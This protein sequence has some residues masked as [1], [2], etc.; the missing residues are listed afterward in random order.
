MENRAEA[1]KPY[2][3]QGSKKEQVAGMFN[4]IAHRYDFLNRSLS[5]G[6]DVLWRRKA[7]AQLEGQKPE[8]ILDVATGTAD[9]ALEAI[10][11]NPKKIIGID[12]SVG[13]LEIGREKIAKRRLSDRIEL[14][15]ADSQNM[16]FADNTFDAVTVAFGVRNFENPVTGLNEIYRVLHEGGKL[17][18]LEFSQPR[19]FP[20]RQLYWFYF[21]HILPFFGR[22]FSKDD[23]A[24]TYLPESVKAFPDGNGFLQI[25]SEAGFKCNTSKPLTFG[26][27]SIY[28]GLKK[29]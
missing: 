18:V 1:V 28:T 8:M 12:I 27:S 6:I 14:V 7:I 9:L 23:S 17:V 5:L 26:I 3:Q 10:R 4:N 15:E 2:H 21:N 11:L 16:P 13:M 19:K 29:A 22:L 20:I 25:M 24:Y